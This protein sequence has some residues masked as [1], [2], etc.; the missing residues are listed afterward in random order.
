[1]T[2]DREFPTLAARVATAFLEAQR[3]GDALN[4]LGLRQIAEIRAELER[5]LVA[6]VDAVVAPLF[7]TRTLDAARGGRPDPDRPAAFEAAWPLKPR[8]R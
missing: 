4:L 5:A 2:N 8:I 1:M 6:H 3:R 7:A